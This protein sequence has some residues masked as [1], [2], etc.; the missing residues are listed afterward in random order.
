MGG[1]TEDRRQIK[2]CG[3]RERGRPAY[4]K[5]SARR[6]GGEDGRLMEGMLVPFSPIQFERKSGEVWWYI[7]MIRG[8]RER[9]RFAIGDA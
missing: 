2:R 9:S 4:T 6:R 7:K 5:V 1:R 3:D 8:S